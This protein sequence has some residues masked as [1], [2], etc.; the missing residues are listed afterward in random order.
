MQS[1]LY[2]LWLACLLSV[3]F[4]TTSATITRAQDEVV[5][6]NTAV[7]AAPV[8]SPAAETFSALETAAQQRLEKSLAELAALRESIAAEKLPLGRQ[9]SD[10]ED[11]LLEVRREYQEATR[12]LDNRTLDL[13][14]LRTEIK[15]RR[16]EKSFV[17]NQLS[18]YA[19][20]FEMR[21][22]IAELQRYDDVLETAKL[23]PENSNL[24][25][26]KVFQAQAALVTTSLDR[27]FDALG[28]TRFEGSAVD[29]S[30][31]VKPGT[32]VLV[33]PAALFRST[34]GQTVGTAEQR[35]G[36]LEP[37]VLTFESS[38]MADEAIKVVTTGDG[39][40]PLDPT[41]G[42]AHKIEATKQTLG[43]HISKGG[44]VM[45]PI[46]GLFV[47]AMLVVMLKWVELARLRRPSQRRID[48]LL[49]AVANRN[50]RDAQIEAAAVG[51]PTGVMLT[52]GVEHLGEPPALIEEVMYEKIL[53][54][55]L[56]LQRFLPFVAIS[57]AA[58]PLLGL[59]GTVT[60][61]INTFK[62]ITVHG[63]GDVK[64]LSSGISEALITTE[65]GL[66]VAIPSLLLHAFLS[67]KA[68]G[69]IA[70]MEKAA[71]TFM[72]QI[73]KTP[74][75]DQGTN[76]DMAEMPAAVAAEVVRRLNLP[77][78]SQVVVE[79]GPRYAPDSVGS[80][81]QPT[82]IKVSENATVAEAL[83]AIR[84]AGVDEDFHAVFVVDEDGKYIGD[85]HIRMLLTRP[86]H[87]QIE[88]LVDRDSL[89]VHTDAHREEVGQLFRTHNLSVV[90]VID[91]DGQL[92]GR[93]IRNGE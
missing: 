39:N 84:Q 13:S 53:T 20:N 82:V 12:L 36:S 72:N 46:L 85:L 66:I 3:T 59:L 86:E 31:L 51:G 19:R 88:S 8:P 38:S 27:L 49:G 16:E 74:Y 68:R 71:I 70:Q 78:Q 40:F 87:A 47:A 50:E 9:L 6:P 5:D 57:A 91:H 10:L 56:K 60:G 18:E 22:H 45:Y 41:L 15:V 55:K 54:A 58:A 93:V 69:M 79:Q 30:G 67:R 52:A 33:G 77:G 92:V 65:F 42:N 62:L 29:S 64:M 23:A 35:L 75:R 1:K 34:D 37:T 24:S 63:S 11:K 14:N 32:F 28:G 80:I 25:E 7:A 76:K 81:M 17:S 44:V 90:P 4:V 26:I 21:L 2:R 89:S 83:E 73:S 43:E 61:I 48:A